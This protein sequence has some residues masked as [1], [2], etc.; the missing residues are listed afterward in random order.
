MGEEISPNNKFAAIQMHRTYIISTLLLIVCF[1]S[2]KKKKLQS[3]EY[4]EIQSLVLDSAIGKPF[5]WLHDTVVLNYTPILNIDIED[6]LVLNKLRGDKDIFGVSRLDTTNFFVRE[7]FRKLIQSN[8]IIVLQ[9]SGESKLNLKT[10]NYVLNITRETYE[11]YNSIDTIGKLTFYPLFY[12]SSCTNAI[13]I[14][15][16]NKSMDWGFCKAYFLKKISGNWKIVGTKMLWI[17]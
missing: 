2:C 10:K 7:E 11:D 13:Q 17:S 9:D 3:F 5:E 15:S 6:S 16:F 4:S 12:N 8:E 1:L 14:C